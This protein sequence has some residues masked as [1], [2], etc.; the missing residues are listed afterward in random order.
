MLQIS[1]GLNHTIVLGQNSKVLGVGEYR[2]GRLGQCKPDKS[3]N[4][5]A[6]PVEIKIPLDSKKKEVKEI[7]CNG[8]FGI[9]LVGDKDYGV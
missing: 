4:Y 9:A 1:S 7:V 8:N 3:T 6:Q 2:N 5:T